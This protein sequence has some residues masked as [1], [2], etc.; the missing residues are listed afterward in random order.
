MKHHRDLCSFSLA[1]RRLEN[2]KLSRRG[3]PRLQYGVATRIAHG[4]VLFN[5]SLFRQN[6]LSAT[7]VDKR[8]TYVAETKIWNIDGQ[9]LQS[10][11]APRGVVDF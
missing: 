5:V 3:A 4:D 7:V 2:Q 10:K 6:S 11:V 9:F 8:F 1:M